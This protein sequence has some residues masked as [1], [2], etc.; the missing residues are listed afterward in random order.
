MYKSEVFGKVKPSTSFQVANYLLESTVTKQAEVLQT[1]LNV[2][3]Q[4]IIS[5]V[6]HE[7]GFPFLDLYFCLPQS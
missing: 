5:S 3:K 1:T 2:H 6:L 4:R 7:L